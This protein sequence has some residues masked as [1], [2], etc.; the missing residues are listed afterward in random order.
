MIC[1]N[2]WT[3]EDPGQPGSYITLPCG[4]CGACLSNRRAE[5]SYRLAMEYMD[6]RNAKFITLTYSDEY[7]PTYNGI[8]ILD[9]YHLQLFH[10]RLRK[11]Q[12]GSKKCT[13]RYYSVGEYG[14]RTLRPHY[15]VIAF[16]I[17]LRTLD[18]LP[19]LWPL[20]NVQVG[21][22]NSASIYYIT[23]FHVN[24]NH[25]NNRIQPEFCTMSRKPG[26]GFQYLKHNTKY[27]LENESLHVIN[28]G[29]KQK[30][31]RFYK[32]KIFTPDQ[33]KYLNEIN[34]EKAIQSVF[35][36]YE[37]LQAQGYAQ[38]VEEFKARI[39]AAA[40]NVFKKSRY[41]DTF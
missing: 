41:Q 21:D 16:N 10:K 1:P 35:N 27:H 31:P 24:K 34:Q 3:M 19:T 37:R 15:H 32:S 2:S 40:K 38:P 11:Y 25:S 9:P 29:Y 20:G 22:V 7:L 28:N 17:D 8:G 13:Y 23:K 5:W 30:I 4:K 12:S 39:Q 6:S 26:I 14:T 18:H 33:L 36:E